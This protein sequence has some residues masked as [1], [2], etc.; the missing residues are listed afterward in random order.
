MRKTRIFEDLKAR[1]AEEK[2]K[3]RRSN[4]EHLAYL[5]ID[6]QRHACQVFWVYL[7]LWR[8]Y[9]LGHDADIYLTNPLKR[10]C[11]CTQSISII[12]IPDNI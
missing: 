12:P 1:I 9:A 8:H 4:S 7:T 2:D 11:S 3:K 5:Q 10:N 6:L